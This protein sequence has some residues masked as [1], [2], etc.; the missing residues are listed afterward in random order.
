VNRVAAC[1][2]ALATVGCSPDTADE[3][4]LDCGPLARAACDHHAEN[5]RGYLKDR[6][7]TDRFDASSSPTR[8]VPTC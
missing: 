4:A 1:L 8:R 5:A 2:V 3:A 7:P 6:Y